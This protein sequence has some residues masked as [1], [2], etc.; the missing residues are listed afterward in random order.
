MTYA[1]LIV[2]RAKE[3]VIAIDMLAQEILRRVKGGKF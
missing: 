2:P 1:D 3:N